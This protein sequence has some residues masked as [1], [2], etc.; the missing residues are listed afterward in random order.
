L[1]WNSLA[2]RNQGSP[3]VLALRSTLIERN[4]C[5]SSTEQTLCDISHDHSSM[6]AEIEDR[7]ISKILCVSLQPQGQDPSAC[8]PLSELAQV[9]CLPRAHRFKYGVTFLGRCQDSR[10]FRHGGSTC[11][12]TTPPGHHFFSNLHSFTIER[13][14]LC[15]QYCTSRHYY[16]V[17]AFVISF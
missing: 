13:Y 16:N 4:S 9:G 12:V 8:L 2:L 5:F 1:N 14:I 11:Q 15:D 6:A 17:H 3:R 7:I 10:T